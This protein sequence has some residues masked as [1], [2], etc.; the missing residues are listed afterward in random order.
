VVLGEVDAGFVYYS[1]VKFAS[2]ISMIQVPD[3]A[4]VVAS[5][6]VAALKN[7]AQPKAAD[8]FIGFILSGAGQEIL[9]DHGFG[10]PVRALQFQHSSSRKVGA[11][12]LADGPASPTIQFHSLPP[13]VVR[14]PSHV[15]HF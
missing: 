13:V 2:D 8:A 11:V 1:D 15:D 9:R 10:A 7:S 3:E 6:T 4:N 5:Y 14:G 12:D